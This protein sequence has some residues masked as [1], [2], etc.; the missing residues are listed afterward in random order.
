M[1]KLKLSTNLQTEIKDLTQ[2]HLII[3]LVAIFQCTALEVQK[4]LTEVFSLFDAID[5]LG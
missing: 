4:Q 3:L 1:D 2:I 5:L